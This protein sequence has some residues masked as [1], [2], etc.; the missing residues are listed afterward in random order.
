[1]N[2]KDL[3]KVVATETGFPMKDVQKTIDTFLKELSEEVNKE[4]VAIKDFG[5]FKTVIQKARI[6]RNPATGELVEVP[7]KKVLKFKP[8]KNALSLKW[9]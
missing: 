4:D 7:E 9:L 6:A 2:K 1:M 5:T 3:I 8:S